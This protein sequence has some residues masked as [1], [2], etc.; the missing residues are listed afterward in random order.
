MVLARDGEAEVVRRDGVSCVG[1]NGQACVVANAKECCAVSEEGSRAEELE[2][3][4]GVWDCDG[5]SDIRCVIGPGSVCCCVV[6]GVG[7]VVCSRT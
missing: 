4:V 2:V 5:F 1:E 7:W 3:D 6:Y